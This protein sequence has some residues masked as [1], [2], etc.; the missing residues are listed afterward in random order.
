ME[1]DG[2]DMVDMSKAMR[3]RE[4]VFCSRCGRSALGFEVDVSLLGGDCQRC[5][6]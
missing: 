6:V 2:L 3:R 1:A 4:E 5:V